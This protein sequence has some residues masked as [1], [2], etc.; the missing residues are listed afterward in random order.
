M[1]IAEM[2]IGIELGL[3][4][5]G[6]TVYDGFQ[7]EELDWFINKA[8][9]QK[10][11]SVLS[12]ER[13]PIRLG[14]QGDQGRLDDIRPLIK[15]DVFSSAEYP[16]DPSKDHVFINL[17]QDYRNLVNAR[18][19]LFDPVCNP[20]KSICLMMSQ[21]EIN[22]RAIEG[23]VCKSTPVIAR[24]I[25]QN[26]VYDIL[27]NPF[28]QSTVGSPVFTISGKS[29]QIF[30]GKN[31][32]VTGI[33]ADYIRNPIPV[34]VSLGQDCELAEH[35]HYRIVDIVVDHLLEITGSPRNQAGKINLSPS[36]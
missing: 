10:V 11:D 20:V 8:I 35:V 19:N 9:N 22:E 2:H 1:T 23:V 27:R 32:I 21:E 25:R 26:K 29:Y 13:D 31:Y 6:S 16:L 4:K 14:F 36:A 34:S 5:L 24:G 33:T 12:A 28:T 15:T 30:Q 17:P 7:P 18:I 3:N